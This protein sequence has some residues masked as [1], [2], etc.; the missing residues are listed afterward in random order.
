MRA[1]QQI[2]DGTMSPYE[3]ELAID[4]YVKSNCTYAHDADGSD[5]E[6]GRT[7][8]SALVEGK[9][10]CTGYS[11]GAAYMLRLAGVPCIVL[12]GNVKPEFSYNG[13]TGHVWLMVEINDTWYHYDPTWDDQDG[14]DNLDDYYP[15]LNLST[16]EMRA[17]RV[18]DHVQNQYRFDLP[19]A[20]SMDENY[21]VK[22]GKM[23][24]GA[25]ATEM[26]L[27]TYSARVSGVNAVGMVFK[28]AE[29]YRKFVQNI[30]D[31]NY[32]P[33]S[34]LTFEIGYLTI[35]VSRFVYLWW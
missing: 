9:A 29:D 3:K 8:H 22:S 28:D 12:E 14:L 27:L 7:A 2:V 21:Y 13:Y 4:R 33:L 20:L 25:W 5:W 34:I 11:L 26:I 35:D 18:F 17:T 23:L 15:F 6:Y 30:L 24:D 16:A 10:I 1:V 31:E 32:Y 19:Q